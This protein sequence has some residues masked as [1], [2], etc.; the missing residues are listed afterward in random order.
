MPKTTNSD[1]WDNWF[2]ELYEALCK[3]T[4]WLDKAGIN[5]DTVQCAVAEVLTKKQVP[6][7]APRAGLLP[8]HPR[9]PSPGGPAA[10]A[11][12]ASAVPGITLLHFDWQPDGSA[13]AYLDGKP[14]RLSAAPASLLQ[15]LEE[16]TGLVTDALVGWKSLA[17]VKERMAK[18]TGQ[19]LS[20]GGLN[21]VVY[22]LRQALWTQAGLHNDYIQ[23]KPR[24]G[25]IRFARRRD[26]ENGGL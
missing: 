23:R 8:N 12:V 6:S 9:L 25:L 5:V 3:L 7:F 17:E 13:V 22:R 18:K 15:V 24:K 4:K 16:D 26:P 20:T 21:N 10:G 19:V 11:S 1:Q 14:V 2:R